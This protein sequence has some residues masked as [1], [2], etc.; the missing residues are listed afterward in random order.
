MGCMPSNGSGGDRE[1]GSLMMVIGV[2]SAVVQGVLTGPVTRRF[3]EERVVRAGLLLA[4]AGFMALLAAEGMVPVLLASAFFI[5]STAM[6]SP[7]VS[8][9]IS[10]RAAGGQGAAMGLNNSFMSLGRIV[11]PIW[12]GRALDINLSYPF[13]TGTII[14][15]V[16]FLAASVWLRHPSPAVQS[17]TR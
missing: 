11:G 8:S 9:M 6:I 1:V 5:S 16:G 2:V 13:F 4:A 15:L 10:K 17:E 12:A 7:A 14:L 3:G